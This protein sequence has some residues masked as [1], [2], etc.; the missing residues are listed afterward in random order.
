MKTLLLFILVSLFALTSQA[1]WSYK[2]LS[3]EKH[4]VYSSGDFVM[5]KQN[6]GGISLNYIYNNKLTVNIGYSATVKTSADLPAEIL[7]S[8]EN[9][10]PAFSTDPF[11]NSENIRI[12]VGRVFNVNREGTVRLLLQ[13]GPG[14]YTTREPSFTVKSNT[15]NYQTEATKSLSLVLQPKIEMPLFA[16]LGLSAGPMVIF[17]ESEHYFGAGIGLMYGILGKN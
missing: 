5:G 10:V 15:Y 11:S 13:G 9:L 3:K 16:T 7:K 6:G 17:N 2:F 12:L 14:I 1:Q 4:F 8:T